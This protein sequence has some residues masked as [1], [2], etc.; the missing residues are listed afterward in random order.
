MNSIIKLPG[1]EDVTITKMEEVEE[2]LRIHF[3]LPCTVHTCPRCSCPTV[4]V[5][6]YRIQKIKH[7]KVFER[8]T[9]LFYRRRRYACACGKRFSEENPLVE[10]YQRLSIEL[11]QALN[12]RSVK[13]K[14]FK[15]TAEVY[16]TSPSTVVRRFDQLS[17]STLNQEGKE[18][19]KVIAIDEYKGDTNAGKYQ[20]IIADGITREPIDILRN[21]YKNTLKDYLRKYGSQVEVVVMDMSQSFKAAVQQ[22]LGKPVI[23]ADRFHFVRYIYWALDGVRRRVQSMWHDYDRKKCKKMRHVF[24]KKY[25]ALTDQDLWHL[26][27]YLGMSEE[28]KKAY[29]LKETFCEWFEQAKERG[30]EQILATRNDL[31]DFYDAVDEAG[32]PEFQRAVQTLK[33]WQNEILNS[34]RYAYSN[35]FLE[36]INNLTKVMKRNA[37]GFRSFP[38]FRA[39]ILL[40]HKYKKIGKHIG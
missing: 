11:N 22:S 29:E 30:E 3:E 16:G 31:Y 36:G 18:L 15:E 26:D 38:R 6:D 4:K 37:F 25:S 27:R 8:H 12:I 23:V 40:T 20:L 32:I 35:G 5:H 10:R 2:R 21:R 28:L 34:F 13:G 19:P 33:N 17:E 7:L 14:T 9:V 1:F 24:Y 39:K